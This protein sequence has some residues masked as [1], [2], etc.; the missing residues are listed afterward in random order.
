MKQFVYFFK[1]INIDA[2]KIG[3]ASGESINDRFQSF[4]TYSPFGAEIIGYYECENSVDEEKRLHKKYAAHRLY[5]EFFKITIEQ[6]LSEC[7]INNVDFEKVMSLIFELKTKD[8][9]LITIKCAIEN[10]S[11]KL[12]QKQKNTSPYIGILNAMPKFF[13]TKDFILECV[14]FSIKEGAA[15]MYLNSIINKLISKNSHG[16]YMKLVE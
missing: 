16:S 8:I 3:R 7:K 12:I 10:Y 6:A 11:N 15:K 13:T 14:K 1:H 5:G 4:K 2:I 9:E